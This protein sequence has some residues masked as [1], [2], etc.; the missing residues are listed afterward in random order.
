MT[1]HWTGFF[2]EALRL[3]EV[4][5][6][7][8]EARRWIETCQQWMMNPLYQGMSFGYGDFF[9]SDTSLT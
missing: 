1:N 4:L 9:I 8:R 2:E 6:E 7:R 3:R 5:E